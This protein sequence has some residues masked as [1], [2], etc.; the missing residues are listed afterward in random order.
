M[1]VDTTLLDYSRLV[2]HLMN[3][4][5]NYVSIRLSSFETILLNKDF[6][7]YLSIKV[8]HSVV[9]ILVPLSYLRAKIAIFWV[10]CHFS[11]TSPQ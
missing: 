1:V 11:K 9:G 4:S 3:I 6:F 10:C 5:V 7:S 2:G 8:L